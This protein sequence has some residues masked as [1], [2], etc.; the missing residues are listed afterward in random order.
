MAYAAVTL[1][2][3]QT[4]LNERLENSAF[5]VTAEL[6]LALNE[7]LRVWNLYTGTWRSRITVALKPESDSYFTL[8]QS[9]AFPMRMQSGNTPMAKSS[10]HDLDCGK[11][12]WEGQLIGDT[13]VPAAPSVWAPVSLTL[14]AYWPRVALTGTTLTIDGVAAT[15]VLVNAGDYIDLNESR[16][17]VLLDYAK[18]YLSIKR[19]GMELQQTSPSLIAFLEAAADE[20]ALFRESSFFRW[21]MARDDKLQVTPF[22]APTKG[23]QNAAG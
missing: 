17:N 23:R 11:P 15:P 7:A 3:L 12:G 16:H 4:R 14:I 21:A 10:L 18:H 13:G 5:Y 9:M 6:T 2:T 22:H 19:G 1:S 20:N 8:P